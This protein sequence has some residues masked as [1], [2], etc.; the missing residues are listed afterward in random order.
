MFHTFVA[1]IYIYLHI[2]IYICIHLHILDVTLELFR[3]KSLVL[4]LQPLA[5][6]AILP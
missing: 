3:L 6:S 2:Y 5:A 4:K 1:Y